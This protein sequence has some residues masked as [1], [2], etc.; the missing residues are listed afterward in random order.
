[1]ADNPGP[2]A[3]RVTALPTGHYREGRTRLA[4]QS[5]SRL[6]SLVSHL[7]YCLMLEGAVARVR[8]GLTWVL[9][10]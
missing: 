3:K 7:G 4:L 8:D 2:Y 6:W 9:R 1:M 5:P 10:A